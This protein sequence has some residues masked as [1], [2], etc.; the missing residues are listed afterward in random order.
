MCPAEM[1][2]CPICDFGQ[3]VDRSERVLLKPDG[4]R[5]PIL[6]SVVPITIKGEN[7]LLESFI[8]ITERKKVE[9]ELRVK[10]WAIES[11]LNAIAFSDLAGNLTHVNPAFLKLWGYSSQAEVLG[12]PVVGF[13]QMG[14]KAVE[15]VETLQS[16][17]G[18]VGELIAQGKDGAGFEVEVAAS[19]VK[20][21]AGKRVC[22]MASFS[23][24]TE[25]KRT[26]GLLKESAERLYDAQKLAHIGVWDWKPDT[27]TVTWTEELYQIA[28][29]DPLLP[30]PTYID[31]SK[32]YTPESWE[33]LKTGV[34]KAL[35]T[36]ESYQ[37]EL[38]LIR[39]NGESRH[40][41]AFGGAKFDSKGQVIGLFG[42]VQDITERK[43]AE[44]LQDALFRIAQA[45]DLCES[46]DALFPAI[47]AIVQEVM[48]ADNFY[49]A[50]YD[51]NRDI[52]NFPYSVDEMDLLVAPEK[53]GKSLTEYVIRTAKSLLCDRALFEDLKQRGEV[54]LIGV[55]SEIWLGVPMLIEGKVIGVLS[56]QDYKNAGAY[57]EREVRILE[58]VSSQAAIAIHRKRAE[59]T[60]RDSEARYHALF[61]GTA[62]GILIADIE[63]RM[64]TY[65]NPAICRL[66]GYSEAELQTMGVSDIH[67]KTDLPAVL[68]EFEAQASGDKTLAESLPCL[69]KDG[70]I[71]YVDVSAIGMS[72]DGK[73]SNVGFFRDIT[74]RRI[75]VEKLQ[76]TIVG[77]INTIAL[78]VEARDPY[79]SGH[80]KR[81]ATISVAVAKELGLT[82]EQIQ[83]IY[84]ASLIHDVGKIQVPS[85]ILSK[86]GKLTRL[87]F[88]LIKTHSTVGYELLKEIEFP[89]PIAAI[90][91]QHHER[92]NGSGYPR[93][94]KGN[95]ISIEAKIIGIA[96]VIEA[97]SSHRPYRPALGIDFAL[98]EI[99]KN[100][101]ILFDPD[102]VEACIKVI[103]KDKTL[104]PST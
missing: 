90:V 23:D 78:I 8:D 91:Y 12:K 40:L 50:L 99:N 2:S 28:G 101:G 72:I 95:R 22:M 16:Q 7:Y 63:S 6:K 36:G 52:L 64:F 98:D 83:G 80:Q 59:H 77:T 18:W 21:I 93:K 1:G 30:A 56:I 48:V 44:I 33:L 62:D 89:W 84:F 13:W 86:P 73:A 67:P 96:D 71:L 61:Q 43:Q 94:L 68:A 11:S 57:G 81:V 104:L 20:D 49:I 5:V 87:E 79:T 60:L 14:E 26:E 32:L 51:E 69:R 66:L 46:L 76:K 24:I 103:K 27:D 31:H 47:H 35:E 45:T 65:A 37:F 97:I 53:P 34:E 54:E 9:E 70:T 85:E 88:E 39:P 19:M 15:I 75:S 58:F 55:N 74:E 17:G 42:T 92:V 3:V 25:R 4:A 38:E 82:E 102:I 10:D 41:N 100:K 29:L